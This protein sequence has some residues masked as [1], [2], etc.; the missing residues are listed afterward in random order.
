MALTRK[1][2]WDTEHLHSFLAARLP[3]P[4]RWGSNDCCLFAADAVEALTGVDVAAEFRGRYTTK[5]GAFAMIRAVTGGKTLAD[6]VAWCM[7]KHG[8]P[9]HPFPLQA[10]RGD[11]VLLGTDSAGVVS[12]EGHS[13]LCA[14]EGVGIVRRP[15]NE[16]TKAWT[17]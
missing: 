2:G 15:L 3:Q 6:A 16:I 4:Y 10:R 12:P 13:V 8:I 14:V 17:V 7:A 5:R 11:P 9:A 1:H